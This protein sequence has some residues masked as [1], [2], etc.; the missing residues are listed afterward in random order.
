MVRITASAQLDYILGKSFEDDNHGYVMKGGKYYDQQYQSPLINLQ[1][2]IEK[3][4]AQQLIRAKKILKS[5]KEL[6]L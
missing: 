6:Q 5:L 1:K 2:F 4:S 3:A